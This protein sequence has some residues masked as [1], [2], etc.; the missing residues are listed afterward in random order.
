M[1][2]FLALFGWTLSVFL[3]VVGVG[4]Q[5]VGGSHMMVCGWGALVSVGGS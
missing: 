5:M 4:P 2:L 1:L 3:G